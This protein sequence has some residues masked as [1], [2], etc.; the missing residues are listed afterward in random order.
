MEGCRVVHD[1]KAE[2]LIAFDV[3]DVEDVH[4][5]YIPKALSH[6]DSGGS[7]AAA[8]LIAEAVDATEMFG[9]TDYHGM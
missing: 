2:E 5:Q 4:V 3:L 1:R 6:L 8:R 7:G 9:P